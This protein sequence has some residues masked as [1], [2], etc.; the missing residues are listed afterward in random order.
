MNVPQHIAIIMDGNGRWARNKGLPKIMGHRQGTETVKKI[1]S[2]AIK[3]G[4]KYLTLYAFSAENWQR[5]KSEVKALFGL[6]DDFLSTQMQL[7][8]ENNVRLCII[9][10]RERIETPLRKKIEQA[11]KDTIDNKSLMLNIALSYG[12]RQEIV[13]AAKTLSELARKGTIE[14]SEID[15]KLFSEYLYTKD[16]PD[17]DLLIRTSGQMRVSNFLLWQISYAEI[18]VTEKLWPDFN[19]SDLK[20]AIEEYQKRERKFGK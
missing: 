18:Y 20:D 10:E 11:E 16:C 12:A 5:V 9:G 2:A 14:P 7:F 4:V 8:H 19:E 1:I 3:F 15:E 6:L 17:P 13:R